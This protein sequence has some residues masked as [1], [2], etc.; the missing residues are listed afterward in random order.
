MFD[1]GPIA[2]DA[3]WVFELSPQE[4]LGVPVGTAIGQGALNQ[5]DIHDVVLSM[6]YDVTPGGGW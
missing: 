4:I 2:P 6:E 5:S 3:E 1:K